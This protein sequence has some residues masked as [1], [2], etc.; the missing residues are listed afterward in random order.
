LIH[1]ARSYLTGAVLATTLIVVA[2]VAF[3]LIVSAQA[4]RDW[5]TGGFGGGGGDSISV[6]A[7]QRLT[8]AE[9]ARPDRPAV[10]V[11]AAT[12]APAAPAASADLA[13]TG[14]TPGV[15]G[16]PASGAPNGGGGGGDNGGAPQPGAPDLS[17]SQNRPSPSPD[18]DNNSGGPPPPRTAAPQVPVV[19]AAPSVPPAISE[20][21]AAGV[22]TATVQ[23]T[24]SEVDDALD[25]PP[26]TNSPGKAVV[27]EVAGE[28]SDGGMDTET[29]AGEVVEEVTDPALEAATPPATEPFVPKPPT[30]G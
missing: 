15:V 2:I 22:V 5:P 23:E 13:S 29:P 10:S 21:P 7:G 14:G 3:M 1:Q 16:D 17:G 26:Q 28:V 4:L 12:P 8:P 24:I 30:A 18:A 20:T 6:S 27:D 9:P 19:A 25:T 11:A